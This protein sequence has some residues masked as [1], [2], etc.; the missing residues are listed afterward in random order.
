MR[1]HLKYYLT[2]DYSSGR[3][4]LSF[5][6]IN[7]NITLH[8]VVKKCVGSHSEAFLQ[9]IF[10]MNCVENLLFGCYF[11]VVVMVPLFHLSAG[12]PL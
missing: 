10:L 2:V 4:G 9:C 5:T 1:Q 3:L 8:E 7:W 12:F 11:P 6:K